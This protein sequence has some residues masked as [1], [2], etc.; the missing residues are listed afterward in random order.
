MASVIQHVILLLIKTEKKYEVSQT[1]KPKHWIVKCYWQFPPFLQT[2]KQKSR[3]G[4]LH[5]N[6]FAEGIQLTWTIISQIYRKKKICLQA[7]TTQIS[8]AYLCD[9]TMKGWSCLFQNATQLYT[10]CTK[11][12]EWHP[13]QSSNESV[14]FSQREETQNAS[15]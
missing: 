6:Q 12:F 15:E 5:R 9:T 14:M 8:I 10:R 13:K 4:L 1:F 7:L 11:T 3:I 2:A